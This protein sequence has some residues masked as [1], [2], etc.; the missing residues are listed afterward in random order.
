MKPLLAEEVHQNKTTIPGDTR[1]RG[2][3]VGQPDTQSGSVLPRAGHPSILV[4]FTNLSP[5]GKENTAR[6]LA[7]GAPSLTRL[8]G[9]GPEFCCVN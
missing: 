5:S 9:K 6:H 1:S 8:V 3:G 4:E 7:A 2:T